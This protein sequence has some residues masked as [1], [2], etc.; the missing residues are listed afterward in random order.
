MDVCQKFSEGK[1]PRQISQVPSVKSDSF[2]RYY[3]TGTIKPR[4]IGGSKPRVATPNVV[5]RISE[6]KR[7]C[8]SIFAWEIRDR[9]L[10][11][12]VCNNDNVP[13]VSLI[14]HIFNQ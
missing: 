1:K 9:L 4:A 13:S 8:P 6:Y 12:G 2:F 14:K 7:E 3:E 5:K 11:E 10:S